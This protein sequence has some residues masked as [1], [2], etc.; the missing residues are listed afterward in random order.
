MKSTLNDF[1]LK[2]LPKDGWL[3]KLLYGKPKDDFK[4]RVMAEA[5]KTQTLL[6]FQCALERSRNGHKQTLKKMRRIISAKEHLK[7]KSKS[8]GICPSNA[9]FGYAPK[10]LPT[11]TIARIDECELGLN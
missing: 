4:D 7:I 6:K 8:Q 2:I 10:S 11:Q 3:K 1:I 5:K 9:Y